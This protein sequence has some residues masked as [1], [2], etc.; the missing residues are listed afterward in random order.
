MLAFPRNAPERLVQRLG[1]GIRKQSGCVKELADQVHSLTPAPD[2]TPRASRRP[3]LR[4][5][6]FA[7]FVH[8]WRIEATYAGRDNA[9]VLI[10][11][12]LDHSPPARCNAEVDAQYALPLPHDD[13]LTLYTTLR[14]LLT[15]VHGWA[16]VMR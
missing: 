11:P 14:R 2:H 3:P 15:F 1:G 5:F 16:M 7:G 6:R 13:A 12:R 4:T 8:Q 9:A 10:I